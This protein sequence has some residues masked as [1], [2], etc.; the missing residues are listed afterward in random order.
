[1]TDQPD[2]EPEDPEE[3]IEYLEE[4]PDP[5]SPSQKLKEEVGFYAS[6]LLIILVTCAPG[7]LCSLYYLSTVPD[8]TWQRGNDGL[9]IDRVFMVRAR[10]S[11]IGLGYETWRVSETLSNDE[12]CVTIS[13]RYLLWSDAGDEAQGARVSQRFTRG[14]SGWQARGQPCE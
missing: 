5:L 10:R 6:L 12:V 9:I 3:E 11:P 14:Q 8:V 13:I 2:L 1:M 4:E 7:F